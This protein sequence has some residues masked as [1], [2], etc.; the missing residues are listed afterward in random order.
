[1][2]KDNIDEQ[3]AREAKAICK[4]RKLVSSEDTFNTGKYRRRIRLQRE[5]NEDIF[6][7]LFKD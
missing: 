2:R 5:Y 7:R 4:L 1:M 3:A 6:S